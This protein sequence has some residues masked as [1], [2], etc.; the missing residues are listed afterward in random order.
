MT[1]KFIH[2]MLQE[3]DFPRKIALS[4]SHASLTCVAHKLNVVWAHDKLDSYFISTGTTRV[5]FC[6]VIKFQQYR[7][8]CFSDNFSTFCR[9][10]YSIFQ[11][12]MSKL[13]RGDFISLL[14]CPYHIKVQR[15]TVRDSQIY[16]TTTVRDSQI[17]SPRTTRIWFSR[18]NYVITFT[19]IPALRMSF[20]RHFKLPQFLKSN[21][22]LQKVSRT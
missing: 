11:M 2:H 7:N 19:C 18:E 1:R 12:H 13:W 6:N 21:N 5:K 10:Q 14:Y 20:L 3:F 16:K 8:I 4:L 22:L 9:Y 15:L 17:Y